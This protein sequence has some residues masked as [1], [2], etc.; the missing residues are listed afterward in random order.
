MKNDDIDRLKGQM[1]HEKIQELSQ[2]IS[3]LQSDIMKYKSLSVEFETRCRIAEEQ[4][5]YIKKTKD[6]E[7]ELIESKQKEESNHKCRTSFAI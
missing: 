7:I 6:E 3:V 2:Q 4:C 1:G 5:E